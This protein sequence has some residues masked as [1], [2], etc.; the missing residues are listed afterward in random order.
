MRITLVAREDSLAKAWAA[1]FEDVDAVEV[2]QG[3]IF[4]VEC[5]AIVS[6]ANS[7][8]FMDGGIDLMYS[9]HFGWQ[10]QDQLR[11]AI[12]QRH[13]GELL[14]GQAE[15][16]ETSA[17]APAFLIAAPTMRVPMV[18][19]KDSINPYLATRAVLL[20][21]QH[22]HFPMGPLAGAPLSTHLKT[23]AFPGMGTGVGRVPVEICA[24]Q[25]R[26]AYDEVMSEKRSMPGSWAE[27]SERH[28]LLYTDQL[29]RLQ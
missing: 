28:Q 22:G 6:P 26:V 12:F 25:M 29:V 18:L 9:R 24:R 15:I 23:I 14:V 20:L 17:P 1:A 2:H 27:A 13:H 8:G 19:G 5:D 21:A 7:F 4:D 16:V 10:V 3:S 11:R